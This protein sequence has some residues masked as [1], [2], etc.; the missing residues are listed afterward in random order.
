MDD[1]ENGDSS[2]IDND[3]PWPEATRTG[4]MSSVI[5]KMPHLFLCNKF[6]RVFNTLFARSS[7]K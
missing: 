6:A 5:M 1:C 4:I 3:E 7:N 2:D